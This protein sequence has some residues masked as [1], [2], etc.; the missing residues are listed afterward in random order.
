MKPFLAALFTVG[1]LILVFAPKN[2]D[3][4]KDQVVVTKPEPRPATRMG[5]L[6]ARMAALATQPAAQEPTP[7]PES[8]LDKKKRERAEALEKQSE[9]RAFTH[10][11]QQDL[12]RSGMECKVQ[13]RGPHDTTLYVQYALV[14]DAV[15]FQFGEQIVAPY[16]AA[17]REIGFKK[18]ELSDGFNYGWVWTL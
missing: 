2:Q 12:W 13:T 9:K 14:G 15:R 3:Q 6:D 11:F 18:V 5:E 4:P 10:K 8:A 7:K 16:A 17:W 1:L